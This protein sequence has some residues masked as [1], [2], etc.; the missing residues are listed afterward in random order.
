M[1]HTILVI[2]DDAQVGEM[3]EGMLRRHG[4][5]AV[6]VHDGVEAISSLRGS[7]ADMIILDIMMP[8]FSGYW[9][10]DVFKKNPA[11]KHIPVIIV[12]ALDKK[13][14]IEKGLKLGADAY[15]TKPFDEEKLIG[16]IESILS[17]KGKAGGKRG[18]K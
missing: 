8:F 6:V 7:P 1:H 5:G 9:Y 12:S 16:T 14:D 13:K 18:K 3:I 17:R 4:Y 15:L 2:E 10:C 11:T